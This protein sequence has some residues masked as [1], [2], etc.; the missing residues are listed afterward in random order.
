MPLSAAVVRATLAP[1]GRLPNGRRC[2]NPRRCEMTSASSSSSSS[3]PYALF[4]FAAA[5]AFYTSFQRK[6]L[7]TSPGGSR[8]TVLIFILYSLFPFPP[9]PPPA[10]YLPRVS[11]THTTNHPIM[12]VQWRLELFDFEFLAFF[13]G[14][15]KNS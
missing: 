3:Y 9:F 14:R 5:R 15:K 8:L 10:M 13:D 11:Y 1:A 7:Y 6:S 12:Y 4:S 2:T